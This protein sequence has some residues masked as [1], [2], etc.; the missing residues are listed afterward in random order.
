MTTDA[1]TTDATMSERMAVHR[2]EAQERSGFDFG[3]FIAAG[4]AAAGR[5]AVPP[6]RRSPVMSAMY[7]HADFMDYQLRRLEVRLDVLVQQVAELSG[8]VRYLL[9]KTGGIK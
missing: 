6:D 8:Q 5:T 7:T 1:K 2:R 9:E 4:E 3:E